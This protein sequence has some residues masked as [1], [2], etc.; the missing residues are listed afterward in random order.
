ML[1][2]ALFCGVVGFAL[3]EI[4]KH[5]GRELRNGPWNVELKL[6]NV[7]DGLYC[8]ENRIR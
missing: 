8:N 1:V 4:G 6:G 7:P 3:F 5:A 2:C